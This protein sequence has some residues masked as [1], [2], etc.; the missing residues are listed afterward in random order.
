MSWVNIKYHCAM[1]IT[2]EAFG[3]THIAELQDDSCADNFI[4][5]CAI[6]SEACGYSIESVNQ[7][8]K[9]TYEKRI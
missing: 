6:L 2:V 8:L 9:H 4:E 5:M 3:V 7:A 1:K